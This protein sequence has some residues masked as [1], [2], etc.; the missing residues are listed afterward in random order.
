MNHSP[1]FYK[2]SQV[3]VVEGDQTAAN[4]LANYL[5]EQG[6]VVSEAH[7]GMSALAM[8]Q[9]QPFDLV[10]LNLQL[11]D[12][13]G[14]YLCREIRAC[15]SAGV[16][17]T[18]ACNDDVERIVSYESGADVFFPKPLSLRELHACGKNIL[19]RLNRQGPGVQQVAS[20]CL[21]AN[22]Y[23]HFNEET[24]VLG[25]IH[26]GV[27]NLT[28]NESVVLQTLIANAERVMPRDELLKA[29]GNREWSYSDRTIDVLIARLRSKF[30]SLGIDTGCLVT[31]YGIGYM[32]ME[33]APAT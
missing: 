24:Q 26:G 1:C 8:V 20:R 22:E 9:Q 30:K 15:C 12:T 4:G 2:D 28:R 33:L 29:L 32:F 21:Y 31:Q 3:L 25:N 16:I 14:H 18:S 7:T 11:P 27:V 17:V 6:W 13:D 10:I 5:V 23:W 19:A